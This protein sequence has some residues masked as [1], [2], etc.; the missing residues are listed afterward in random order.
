MQ[1]LLPFLTLVLLTSCEQTTPTVRP[2]AS[3]ASTQQARPE[4]EIT[5]TDSYMRGYALYENC[6]W[7]QGTCAVGASAE[8]RTSGPTL[9]TPRV[10]L[11]LRQRQLFVQFLTPYDP[12][13]STITIRP[14]EDFFVAQP[15][16]EALGANAIK[17]KSGRYS[18]DTRT[19]DYGGVRFNV[20]LF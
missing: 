14:G 3:S 2:A 9:R 16:T 17:I 6:I 7:G 19:G 15:E 8:Y 11:S 12:A 18:I 5:T 13:V 20:Q 10:R 1:K 4:Q